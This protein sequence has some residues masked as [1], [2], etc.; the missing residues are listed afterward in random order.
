[1]QVILNPSSIASY[2]QFCQIKQL[3]VFNIRGRLAEFPDEYAS[4]IGIEAPPLS[5]ID[6]EPPEWM[7]DYQS[8][9]TKIACQKR[10]FAV[11]ADCGLGKTQILLDFA[12]YAASNTS[13]RILIVSPLMVVPQTVGEAAAFYDDYSIDV[14]ASKN[15]QLWLDGNYGTSQIGITNYEAIRDELT[16]GNIGGI[17]LDESSMLKSHY[18]KW[19]TKLIELGK[20]C[21]WKLCLTGTPA[22]NDRIEYAN[23]AVFLDQFS[24]VNAF[25]A[26]FFVNRGQ[27]DGRWELKPHALKP[28]YRALSHWSIFLTNPATYGWSDNTESIPPIHVHIHE[29]EMTAEQ[30]AIMRAYNGQL[31]ATDAGGITTRSVYGQLGKGFYKGRRVDTNKPAYIQGLVNGW[32]EDEST[33]IWCIY[34]DE[35]KLMSQTFPDAASLTGTTAQPVRQKAINEF[36]SGSIRELI[37]KPKILGFGLNLQVA[38]R[39]VFSGLQ[40]SYESYYQCIKRSNRYGSKFPLNV[41]IPVTEVE[42]PMVQNVLRKAERVQSDTEEQ[43]RIFKESSQWAGEY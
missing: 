5:V 4:Q 33:L 15:L 1:M 32:R 35:Q 8:A 24:T 23:H 12:K 37:S 34:N 30:R 21:D 14:V 19:G 25:L 42:E 36:K 28:F 2:R 16:G 6:Y 38:T 27:T 7:F 11:F 10:K 17:V 13:K 39:H 26:T 18:G 9:I 40:D 22:P 41:H 29:V 31:F 3:P 43:E 20:G